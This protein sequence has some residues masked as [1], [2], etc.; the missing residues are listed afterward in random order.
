MKRKPLRRNC[1]VISETKKGPAEVVF[2]PLEVVVKNGEFE[3][4]FRE[5]KSLV[6]KE[7]VLVLYK[8]KQVYEKPSDKKRRKSREAEERRIALEAKQKLI[9]SGEWDR[10]Q[11]K[12][13]K[14]IEQRRQERQERVK[15]V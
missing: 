5:F 2:K 3:K 14:E 6:Q 11:E 9:A 1:S 4:A 12:R 15:N 10:R 8:E 13:K 7:K